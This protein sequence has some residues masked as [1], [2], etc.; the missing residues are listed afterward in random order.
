MAFNNYHTIGLRCR[1]GEEVYIER[2]KIASTGALEVSGVCRRG[3]VVRHEAHVV[4]LVAKAAG[5]DA[6]GHLHEPILL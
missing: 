3:C 4:E 1:C 2:L 5:Y 6:I